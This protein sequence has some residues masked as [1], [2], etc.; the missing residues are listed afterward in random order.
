MKKMFRTLCAGLFVLLPFDMLAQDW[1]SPEAEQIYEQ[2]M[3]RLS[4]GNAVEAAAIFQKIA[5]AESGNLRVKKSLAQAYQLSGDYENALAVLNP[6]MAG[7][8]ADPE[9]YRIAA[10]AQNGL[11]DTKK[12]LKI[13]SSG[14]ERFPNSGLLFYEQGMIQKGERKF[15]EALKSWLEGISRDPEFRLNYHEAAIAYVQ[16]EHPV[17]AILY[18]EIF[19]NKEP[20]TPRGSETRIL[21]LDAYQ[22]FFFT[23]AKQAGGNPLLGRE[24]KN[25][26]EAVEKTLLSLFFVVS[27][28]ISTENLTMLRTRFIISW[29]DHYAAQYPYSLFRYQE[30][31]IRNGYFDAYNQWLFGKAE[32]PQQ[33]AG[34]ESNF[35]KELKELDRFKAQNALRMSAEDA[36]N[37]QRNFKGF[38]QLQNT[39][40]K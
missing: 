21:L 35:S 15:E 9:I 28:G 13:L 11:K 2:G 17:W 22:K 25:F 26:Q 20:N 24:P 4:Q 38:F 27:D 39:P 33:F 3:Q 16:S 19:V 34:W 8:E 36:Y 14:L 7:A 31:L 12:A 37:R 6:V 40:K 18:G 30:N 32:N 23:P 1:S 10:L 5:P 29:T